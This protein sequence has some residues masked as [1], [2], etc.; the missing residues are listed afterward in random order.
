LISR[1]LHLSTF[2]SFLFKKHKPYYN[3]NSFA[4]QIISIYKVKR[5]NK[6]FK[7]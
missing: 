7:G 1:L 5:N 3:K 4:T 6:E 2:G